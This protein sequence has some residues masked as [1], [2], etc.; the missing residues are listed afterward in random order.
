MITARKLAETPVSP[1]DI[2]DANPGEIRISPDGTTY[3]DYTPTS[4]RDRTPWTLR[5]TSHYHLMRA[6]SKAVEGWQV[7]GHLGHATAS[8][9]EQSSGAHHDQVTSSTPVQPR[10]FRPGE[11]IPDGVGGV[12]DGTREIW[13]ATEWT[14]GRLTADELT[15]LL[16]P[17]VEIPVD[18]LHSQLPGGA[19]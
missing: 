19:S 2:P 14:T 9:P 18:W 17:V 11:V 3:A 12:V 15:R 5:T 16:G 1:E 13:P 6:V 4:P 7:V 10:V 8:V